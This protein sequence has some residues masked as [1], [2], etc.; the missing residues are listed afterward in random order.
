MSY[1]VIISE[2]AKRD[3]RESARWMA[4]YSPEKAMLW[5]FDIEAAILTLENNPF[6]CPPAPENSFFP[7][8]IRQMIFGKYR[9]LYFVEDEDVHVLYFRHTAMDSEF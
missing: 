9:I 7:E 2:R 6:R 4:Q 1:T 8:E 3:I 5:H